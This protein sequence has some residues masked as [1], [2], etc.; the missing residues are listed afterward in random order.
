MTVIVG[1]RQ[2]RLSQ[3]QG[4]LSL[5]TI[6]GNSLVLVS[7]KRNK[8]LRT[9][10]NYFLISL[11]VADVSIG[12]VSIPLMTHYISEGE[13]RFVISALVA[14]LMLSESLFGGE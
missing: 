4:L 5:A 14:A 10:S 13:K 9:I 1:V 7:F 11:A 8:G 12:L 3:S 2:T 6:L